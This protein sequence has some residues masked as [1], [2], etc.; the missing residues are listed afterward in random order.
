[1]AKPL[2]EIEKELAKERQLSQNFGGVGMPSEGKAIDIFADKIGSNPE[3]VRQSLWLLDNA[4][5][6]DLERLRSG[7]KAISNLYKEKKHEEK[8]IELK[9]KAKNIKAPE[10]PLARITS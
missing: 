5:E 9:E 2:L 8:V 3:T 10:I 6:E 1:M 7:E 4:P